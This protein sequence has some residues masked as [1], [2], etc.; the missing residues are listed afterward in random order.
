MKPHA[1]PKLAASQQLMILLTSAAL[2]VLTGCA[3]PEKKTMEPASDY[4]RVKQIDGRW[5]FVHGDHKFLSLG[6]NAVQP[7]HT[8]P[9]GFS[10]PKDGRY[11]DALTKYNGDRAAWMADVVARFKLWNFTTVAGFS[12]DYLYTNAPLYHTRVV[13][14][15]EW[16][17]KDNRLI[18]VFSE[19]YAAEVDAVARRDVA[20]SATNRYLIGWFV[21]NEMPWYGERGWPTSPLVSLLSRYMLLPEKAAGKQKLVEFLRERYAGDFAAFASNWTAKADSFETLAQARQIAPVRRESKRDTVAWSGVV[22]DQYFKLA[23][24]TLR[25]YDTNHLFLG[26]RFAERAQE[27]VM[28][29]CGRYADVVSVNHYRKTGRFDDVRVGTIA[30]LAGKPVMI[31]EFSWRSQDN[32]SGCPNTLGADVTVPTQEDRANAFRCYATN[33]LAQP[34]MIGYD[35][36]CYHDQ[37]PTG[38]FDG[39][40][41]SYG[42][43]DIHDSFYTTLLG[44]ITEING[45]ACELHAQSD[46]PM[47]VYNPATL[48]DFRDITIPGTDQA[49]TTPIVFANAHAEHAVWGDTPRGAKATVTPSSNDTLRLQVSPG[50][51]G[52]G[53]TFKP[54]PNLPRNPDAS[55]NVLGVSRVRVTLRTRP[56]VKFAVALQESGHGGLDAQNYDGYAG[57]DGESYEHPEISTVEG[58]EQYIFNLQEMDPT[59]AYGNQRGNNIVDTAALSSI[60]IFFPG[61]QADIDAE[62]VSIEVD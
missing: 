1:C 60:H 21:N 53:I 41:S 52:C 33:V 26:V 40:N 30:A 8:E 24:E 25:R 15:G 14:F 9:P 39:E 49:P 51:W 32:S 44:A 10:M 3:L 6:V 58:V 16:G 54:L 22:A 47:P 46:R 36:F 62:L 19:K 50:G 37:P 45:K 43:V 13:W 5:W 2:A 34:Y 35:W 56:G 27:P 42:L 31:T 17:D 48:A 12:D 29:A 55:V 61:P 38:R 59:A 18:D 20:P 57:A 4:V 23:S 7:K 11:Y 28:A